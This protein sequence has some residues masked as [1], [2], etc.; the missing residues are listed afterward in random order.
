M[1]D[2]I[3]PQDRQLLPDSPPQERPPEDWEALGLGPPEGWPRALRSALAMVGQASQPMAVIW[4]ADK[5]LLSND[6]FRPIIGSGL[7]TAAPWSELRPD[8]EWVVEAGFAALREGRSVLLP[9]TPPESGQGAAFSVGAELVLSPLWDDEGTVLGALVTC[10]GAP[11]AAT[12]TPVLRDMAAYR[13]L[14]ELID[15]GFCLAEILFTPDGAAYDYRFLEI[16][17]AFVQHTG[18]TDPVGRSALE[19]VPDLEHAWIEMYASV[20]RTGRSIRREHQAEPMGRVFDVFAAR[21]GGADSRIIAI[22]FRDITE[23]KARERDLRESDARKAFL[24]GFSDLIRR[25]G[26]AE[27][28]QTR[29]LE[30]LG[31]HLGVNRAVWFDKTEDGDRIGQSYQAGVAALGLPEAVALLQGLE[32]RRLAE[33]EILHCNETR[34]AADLSE[35]VVNALEAA[36]ARAFMVVPCVRSGR[37]AGGVMLH[38]AQPRVWTKA[39][40]LLVTEATERLWPAVEQARAEMALR[41]SEEKFR[42]LAELAPSIV[43]MATADGTIS[44]VSDQWHSFAGT[45]PDARGA[46]PVALFLHPEDLEPARRAW[47]KAQQT[48]AP[49]EMELRNRRRDGVYRWCL[50]RAHAQRGADGQIACWFGTTTDIDDQ[51]RTEEALRASEKRQA[52]LLSLAD[53]LRQSAP[54]PAQKEACRLLAEHLQVDRAFFAEADEPA[55]KIHIAQDHHDPGLSSVAGSY[56]AESFGSAIAH[57]RKGVRFE[58]SDMQTHSALP[59]VVRARFLAG[60]IGACLSVPIVLGGHMVGAVCVTVRDARAWTEAESELLAEA[61]QRIWAAVAQTRAETAQRATDTRFRTLVE[62][63]PQLVWRASPNGRWTWASPQWSAF[64]GLS[65][66]DSQNGGW[67]QAVHPDDRAG[68]ETAWARARDLGR[69]AAD[70][71]LLDPTNGDYRWFQTRALPVRDASGQPIEW[72]GTST[73]VQD[74]HDMQERL[75]T[76]VAELQHRTRNLMAVVMA[77]TDRTMA[78]SK[79]LDAFRPVIQSRLGSIARTSGLLSKLRDD[80]QITFDELLGSV[81]LGAGL[82]LTERSTVTLAGPDGVR[83]RSSTVQ[84]LALA[85]HELAAHAVA[86]GAATEP[87]GALSVSWQRV[88]RNGE[89]ARLSVDWQ[90]RFKRGE[91]AV[92]AQD[93]LSFGRELIERGLPYQLNAETAFALSE[94][95]LT[96]RLSLPLSQGRD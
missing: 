61:G 32:D 46:G 62:G 49:F 75:R 28:V 37:L 31:R 57:L 38:Q 73:D 69:F 34:G 63:I 40:L 14:F 45:D 5:W 89:A 68:A 6:K 90:S 53:A 91:R 87:G 82:S 72:L 55:G 20:V 80:G 11:M 67:L 30:E 8:L 85:L 96:C 54:L 24:L 13:T 10:I 26:S 41:R 59:A 94:S 43:W 39:E 83:L 50:T 3:S 60:K 27:T 12:T 44:Y 9:L 56:R 52:F 64:T 93:S 58:V 18:L 17:S 65:D 95:D 29:A 74:L 36:E 86:A 23:R 48:G 51:K 88:Q 79:T 4:G 78:T 15:Q 1:D 76:L 47:E 70:F 21:V 19:L 33:G 16:N 42:Q 81:L 84:T 35:E 71:R 66:L 77:V 92:A 2:E 25:P 7:G 22:L